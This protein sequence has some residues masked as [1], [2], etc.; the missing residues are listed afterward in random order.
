MLSALLM[1]SS[2]ILTG[3]YYHYPQES[4]HLK[5]LLSTCYARYPTRHQAARLYWH[6]P[7]GAYIAVK[8]THTRTSTVVAPGDMCCVAGQDTTKSQDPRGK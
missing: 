7:Q 6:L 3:Y 5:N 1:V 8:E 4:I 2:L